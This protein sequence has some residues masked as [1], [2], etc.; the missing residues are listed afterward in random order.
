[1]PVLFG[2]TATSVTSGALNIPSKIIS[3]SLANKTGGSITVSIGVLFGST[4]YFLFNHSLSTG[5]E[6]IYPGKPILVSANHQ[7]YIAA[8]GSCDYYVT[9]ETES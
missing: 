8:S 3:F 6:Y 5:V 2:N 1:M 9:I 7:I 4:F